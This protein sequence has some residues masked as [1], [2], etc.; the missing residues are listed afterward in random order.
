MSHNPILTLTQYTPDQY[1]NNINKGQIHHWVYPICPD[2][3]SLHP[4][5]NFHI[6]CRLYMQPQI[7]LLAQDIITSNGF[8]CITKQRP[9]NIL[10][11]FNLIILWNC[12]FNSFNFKNLCNLARHKYKT[13]WGLHRDVETCRSVHYIKRCCCDIYL[14]ISW[15]K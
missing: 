12:N 1:T 6:Y 8:Y 15:L 13:P 5:T 4:Y 11:Y 10:I 9:N 7:Q 2:I 3:I 14:C